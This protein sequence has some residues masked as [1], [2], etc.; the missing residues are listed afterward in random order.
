MDPEDPDSDPNHSQNLITSSFYHCGHVL[1]FFSKSIN[2]FLS[3]VVHKQT[4]GQTD[5]PRRKHN[6]LDRGK[7]GGGLY[8]ISAV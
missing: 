3:Y 5:K 2:K 4:D 6:L 7:N 1:K 8:P